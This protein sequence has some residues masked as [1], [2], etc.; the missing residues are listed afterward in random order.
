MVGATVAVGA[1]TLLMGL[2]F[3]YQVAFANRIY[4]GVRALGMDLGGYSREDAAQALKGSLDQLAQRQLALRYGDRAWTMSAQ[5]LGLRTDLNP[6]LDS[7]FAVGREGNPV[8]RF[9]TQFGLW[10]RGRDF[11]QPNAVFD[12]AVQAEVLG[13]IGREI[14]RPPTEARLT[15]TPSY[16]VDLQPA[17]VGLQLDREA[18]RKRIADALATRD[19]QQVDLAVRET[20]PTNARNNLDLARDQA[21]RI[22]AAPIV[23]RHGE[24]SW[25]LDQARLASILRFDDRLDATEA[26]YLDR[27]ALETW[28]TSLSDAVSRPPVDARFAWAGGRLDVIRPSQDGIELDVKGTV[29]SIVEAA[30]GDGREFTLPVT[31]TRPAVP[32]EDR[33][34]LGIKELIESSKTPFAGSVPAK[35]HNITLAAQR[36]NGV[37]VPAGGKFSFNQELG[38]TSL[39][40]GWQIGWGITT[41]GGNVKT[42]PSVAGGICQVATTLF[43]SVFW[44]GYP[45]EER[46]WHL[47][48]IQSYTSKGVVGLDATVDEEAGLD[49]QFLNPTKNAVLIQAWVDDSLNVNF[50]LYSTKPDWVVKVDPAEKTD[51]VPADTTTTVIE[52]EPTLPKGNRLQVERAVDGFSITNVRRVVQ[53]GDER[54]L[55]LV[56]RYRPARNVILVGTGGAPPSSKPVVETNKPASDKPSPAP[57]ATA[58]P[59]PAKTGT[60]APATAPTRAAAE[61][62]AL[63]TLAPAVVPTAAPTKAPPAEPT[64]KPPAP[65]ATSQKRR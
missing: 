65:T 5:E 23:V 8:L 50:A 17:Q 60:P 30:N 20:P 22:L 16:T 28:A 27:S 21:S 52:E 25:V 54:T 1:V 4:P 15:V 33:Q 53:G 62:Q 58:T 18:S 43:H 61:V 19:G 45:I 44:S 29:G 49:F 10:R 47:Y 42:V 36:L 24:R 12:P 40:A 6:I 7:A 46:N 41:S 39:D 34:K 13:R 38:S 63:P 56:S 3:A 57:V 14:D 59:A 55:R 35:Q 48:W 64:M 2:L 51:V 11:E 31:V 37:V 32:A 9:T 26:A